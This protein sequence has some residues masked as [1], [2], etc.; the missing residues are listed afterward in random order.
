MHN[1]KSSHV[2]TELVNKERKE[3]NK[4]WKN[5]EFVLKNKHLFIF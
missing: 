4:N 3:K 5:H 1:Y 2:Y